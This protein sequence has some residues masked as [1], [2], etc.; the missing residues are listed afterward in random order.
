[1]VQCI[2][3]EHKRMRNVTGFIDIII[4]INGMYFSF[5]RAV[6]DYVIRVIHM[7]IKRLNVNAMIFMHQSYHYQFDSAIGLVGFWLS[8]NERIK[9]SNFSHISIRYTGWMESGIIIMYSIYLKL[10]DHEAGLWML[11]CDF[12]LLAFLVPLTLFDPDI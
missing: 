4:I 1:M 12:L 9:F 5:Y 6:M 2:H 3:I 7:N 8:V 11:I 10:R